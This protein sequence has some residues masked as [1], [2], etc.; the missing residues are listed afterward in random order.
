MSWVELAAPSSLAINIDELKNHLR[1]TSNDED[2]LIEMYAK[3]A[4]QLFEIKTSRRLISRSVRLDLAGFPAEGDP[5]G[6]GLPFS[7]VSA[8]THIKYYDTSD[9]L[10]TWNSSQYVVDLTSHFPKIVTAPHCVFPSTQF[11]RPNAVQVTFV[12]GYGSTFSSVPEGI[13]L[14]VFFLAA[15]CY[16][17]RT[18]IVNGTLSEVPKTLQY[19]IDA[20]K[21]WRA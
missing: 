14:A 9:E 2:S 20:Y 16:T 7:P 19:A 13:Q 18:P 5:A 17:M 10:Q 8:I 15:H 6:I 3:A 21:L 4:T 12:T 11:E 1:V